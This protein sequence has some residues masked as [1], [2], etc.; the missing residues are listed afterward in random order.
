[1]FKAVPEMMIMIKGII[2]A[3]SA[4]SYTMGLQIVVTYVFAIALT[5]L[6]EGTEFGEEFLQGVALSMYT[7]IIYGTFCDDLSV[8]ADA[9]KEESS[10]CLAIIALY[11]VLASMTIMN[12]LIGVLCEVI[13]AVAMEE[14]ETISIDKVNEAFTEIMNRL[15]SNKSGTLSWNE[16]N[17]VMDMPE[18]LAAF[19]SV[20]VDPEAVVEFSEDWFLDDLGEPREVCLEEFIGMVL[21]LRGGQDC[22]MKDL[23]YQSKRFNVKFGEANCHMDLIESKLDK[24][25]GLLTKLINKR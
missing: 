17:L 23:M 16:F 24:L 4:V 2:T 6:A 22:Q 14:K 25:Q 20:N 11:I 10:V 8:L 12:M 18:A 15:D 13:S 7:L 5:Q 19:Q 9:V 21:D 3:T 1:M